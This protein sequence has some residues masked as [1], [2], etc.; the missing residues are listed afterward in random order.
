MS[1]ERERSHARCHRHGC[2]HISSIIDANL[3]TTRG[4]GNISPAATENSSFRSVDH[5][6]SFECA[7]RS[8]DTLDTRSTATG[9]T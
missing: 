5:T 9:T 6:L 7:E 2:E 8:G 1:G 3:S 4:Y